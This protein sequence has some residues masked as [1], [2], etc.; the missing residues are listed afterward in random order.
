MDDESDI[1]GETNDAGAGVGAESNIGS[2]VDRD[3]DDIGPAPLQND[4]IQSETYE[5]VL[6]LNASTES[7]A[8][9]ANILAAEVAN[10]VQSIRGEG[11]EANPNANANPNLP[12]AQFNANQTTATFQHNDVL[13]VDGFADMN[14]TRYAWARAFP[15][16]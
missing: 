8:G 4:V 5:G 1:L 6:P 2:L 16:I 9:N 3:G 10:V 7:A 12:Q 11:A 15:S 14:K 13:P